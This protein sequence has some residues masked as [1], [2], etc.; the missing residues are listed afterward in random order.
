MYSNITPTCAFSVR[1]TPVP[2]KTPLHAA[3]SA[4]RLCCA[5]MLIDQYKAPL[6][7]RDIEGKTPAHCA[8]SNGHWSVAEVCISPTLFNGFPFHG[9]IEHGQYAPIITHRLLTRIEC[10]VVEY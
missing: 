2:G 6:I 3:A 10:C 8:A 4:G 5:D 1:T 9:L 7:C